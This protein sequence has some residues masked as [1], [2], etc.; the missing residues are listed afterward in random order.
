MVT[1]LLRKCVVLFAGNL[2]QESEDKRVRDFVGAKAQRLAVVEK[3]GRDLRSGHRAVVSMADLV[4]NRLLFFLASHG[5]IT[6]TT[7][8]RPSYK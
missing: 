1:G 5:L 4:A 3:N 2:V 7:T 6:Q 8:G